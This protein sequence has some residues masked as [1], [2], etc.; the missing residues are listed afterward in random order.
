[1]KVIF[2]DVDGVLNSSKTVERWR[3]LI[4]IDASLARRFAGLQQSTG[5]NVVLSSTWRL[6]RTWRSTMRKNGVVGVIDRTPDLPGRPRGEEIEAW[7]RHPE[8]EVYAILDDEFA[9]ATEFELE[10]ALFR[11]HR[12]L[13]PSFRA[14]F[15]RFSDFDF[16][17]MVPPEAG[18]TGT[19]FSCHW[20]PAASVWPSRCS[21]HRLATPAR[22]ETMH[23]KNH[24]VAAQVPEQPPAP[25]ERPERPPEREQS[26]EVDSK[27]SDDPTAPEL[28]RYPAAER[29]D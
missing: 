25:N 21:K 13:A 12:P 23:G 16:K 5:A 19:V 1:M 17:P 3:G 6:S 28:L 22:S 24:K 20:A 14:K 18:A 10:L 15:R 4:G 26:A 9:R 8:V 27:Y 7:L 2:L 11:E 29:G